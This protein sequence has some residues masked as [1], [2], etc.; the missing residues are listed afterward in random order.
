[1]NKFTQIKICSDFNLNNYLNK[2]FIVEHKRSGII[3]IYFIYSVNKIVFF[4]KEICRY[5]FIDIYFLSP[6]IHDRFNVY[7]I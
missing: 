6:R 5:D 3:G 7:Y 4:N 2:F 1:M